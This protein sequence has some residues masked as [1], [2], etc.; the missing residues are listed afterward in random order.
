MFLRPATALLSAL[1]LAGA[2]MPAFAQSEEDIHANI[3][4]IHGN[5]DGF[6]EVFSLLQDAVM[7]GDPVTWGQY[8]FFPLTVNANG[9]TYDVLEEQD[10]AD[11]FDM[12][13]SPDTQQALLNQDV[14]D[15]IVTDEGVGIGNGAV[16]ITNVC[17]DDDCAQ[18]QWGII[19]INN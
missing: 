19:A 2:A 17:L 6:F 16:W 10:L 12:L 1:L 11:N 8:S 15:L 4:A 3:E 14:A 5:A 9:E 7:F 18:T 13:V